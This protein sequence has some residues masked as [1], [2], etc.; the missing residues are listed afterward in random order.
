[1]LKEEIDM[2]WVFPRKVDFGDG[3]AFHDKGSKC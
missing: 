1:V 2:A 3:N